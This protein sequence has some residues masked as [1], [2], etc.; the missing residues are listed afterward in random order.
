MRT[1]KE[2]IA[3]IME[4]EV[5]HSKKKKDECN[6]IEVYMIGNKITYLNN[7]LLSKASDEMEAWMR[8]E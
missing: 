6:D 5:L 3:K 4:L 8:E 2:I 7:Y 1:T